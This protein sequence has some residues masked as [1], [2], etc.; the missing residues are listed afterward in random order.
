M[1]PQST[2]NRKFVITCSEPSG[3]VS[4]PTNM[5]TIATLQ[6][7]GPMLACHSSTHVT[8]S[9]RRHMTSLLLLSGRSRSVPTASS[10]LLAATTRSSSSLVLYHGLRWT[11][12]LLL[13]LSTRCLGTRRGMCWHTVRSGRVEQCLGLMSVR[14]G[15]SARIDCRLSSCTAWGILV[16]VRP[17]VSS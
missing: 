4:D 12:F 11:R 17:G 3:N 7:A 6:W 5:L 2:G 15:R 14:L 8:G 10:L 1:F 13:V 9:W 16:F